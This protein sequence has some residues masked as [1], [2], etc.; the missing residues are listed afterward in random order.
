VLHLKLAR[1]DSVAIGG[2]ISSLYF[3]NDKLHLSH[4]TI[5]YRKTPKASS[6]PQMQKGSTSKAN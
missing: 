1:E 6:F 2:L 3:H 5:A 4:T